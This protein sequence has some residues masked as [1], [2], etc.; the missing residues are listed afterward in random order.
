MVGAPEVSKDITDW[1]V[2]E[3]LPAYMVLVHKQAH[4]PV[5][6]VVNVRSGPLSRWDE[7]HP[8]LWGHHPKCAAGE[9]QGKAP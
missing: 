5:A 4:Q 6:V 8:I 9:T 3:N 1:Q 7:L 2:T